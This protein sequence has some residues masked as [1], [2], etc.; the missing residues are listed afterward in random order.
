MK[1]DRRAFLQGIG[2]GLILAAAI[3]FSILMLTGY[4]HPEKMFGRIIISDDE[5][6]ERAEDM[7]MI[8]ISDYLNGDNIEE[9]SEENSEED[10]E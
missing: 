7:G 3:F 2:A 9:D 4:N 10:S 1:R 8:F 6:I 5:V